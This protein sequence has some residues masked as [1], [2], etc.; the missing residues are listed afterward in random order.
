MGIFFLPVHFQQLHV[1]MS[2][3]DEGYIVLE[4]VTRSSYDTHEVEKIA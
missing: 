4:V 2:P 3:L 1:Y